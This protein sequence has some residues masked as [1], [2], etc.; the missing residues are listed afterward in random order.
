MAALA[1]RA[2]ELIRVNTE[3]KHFADPF[4]TAVA[5]DMNIAK[6]RKKTVQEPKK[7][8]EAQVS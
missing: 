3:K 7:E 5:Y 4:K 2:A 1:V 6:A 8:S